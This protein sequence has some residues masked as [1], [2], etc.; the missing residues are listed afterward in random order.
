MEK[1][2]KFD[3]PL[4]Y[5]NEDLNVWQEKSEL[6]ILLL[7]IK[8]L[9]PIFSDFV[10]ALVL[11]S[12]PLLRKSEINYQNTQK[13]MLTHEYEFHYYPRSTFLHERSFKDTPILTSLNMPLHIIVLSLKKP[14]ENGD[15][16]FYFDCFGCN[17]T[18]PTSKDRISF[19]LANLYHEVRYSELS[20]ITQVKERLTNII[21]KCFKDIVRFLATLSNTPR[22]F[23]TAEYLYYLLKKDPKSLFSGTDADLA[24]ELENIVYKCIISEGL[25]P[26][27]CEINTMNTNVVKL[28]LISVIMPDSIVPWSPKFHASFC[29][30]DFHYSFTP[31][32]RMNTKKLKERVFN[33]DFFYVRIKILDFFPLDAWIK[34]IARFFLDNLVEIFQ[35]MKNM[36]PGIFDENE[37]EA[38]TT[39]NKETSDFE[40]ETEVFSFKNQKERKPL[41]S[42]EKINE[43]AYK[44][45]LQEQSYDKNNIIPQDILSEK[46]SF[47]EKPMKDLKEPL[48]KKT[49]FLDK[50]FSRKKTISKNVG[51]EENIKSFRQFLKKDWDFI[52]IFPEI[53][54]LLTDISLDF[55]QN[56]KFE[57][58]KTEILWNIS[59]IIART[60]LRQYEI[61]S[62]NCQT[63]VAES[64]HIIHEKLKQFIEP[65]Q[66]KKDFQLSSKKIQ[67]EYFRF[68]SRVTKLM[69]EQKT[70]KPM[71]LDC[72]LD[73]FGIYADKYLQKYLE[74]LKKVTVFENFQKVNNKISFSEKNIEV[75]FENFGNKYRT[76]FT[77]I[78]GNSFLS[79]RVS[80]EKIKRTFS[81]KE[82]RKDAL[83]QTSNFNES[84]KKEESFYKKSSGPIGHQGESFANASNLEIYKM[85]P[86]KKPEN[87]KKVSQTKKDKIN[88]ALS[89]IVFMCENIILNYKIRLTLCK[90][91]EEAKQLILKK[92]EMISLYREFAYYY[93]NSV[94][95][96][97]SAKLNKNNISYVGFILIK[98]PAKVLSEMP[99]NGKEI[100]ASAYM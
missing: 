81:E 52:A 51:N 32:N 26:F 20:L 12:T 2:I 42:K 58:K 27:Y 15:L 89:Y 43:E 94:R 85:E 6:Q 40:A 19:T 66:E 1:P 68:S 72:N 87:P 90:K 86:F 91:P 73:Y 71:V 5:Y 30:G 8:H 13:I 64:L 92:Y 56:Y 77:T 45:S 44:G 100:Y 82:E 55:L 3:E 75:L 28:A 4:L 57:L 23:S 9:Q 31:N 83:N 11:Q 10:C 79:N 25:F 14:D 69:N 50:I 39:R 80:D 88:R 18:S 41:D 62:N 48:L 37:E 34:Q 96:K 76:V 16:V 78:T 63:P 53:E 67:N 61:W 21:K 97:N 7:P 36:N 95:L 93:F 60:E 74:N 99:E 29:I 22:G 35:K 59:K 98:D 24:T 84:S 49:C 54:S 17:C 70:L 38:E 33:Q 46:V 65:L 47:K